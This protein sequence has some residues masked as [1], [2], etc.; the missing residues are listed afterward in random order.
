MK[1]E[2]VENLK[3]KILVCKESLMGSPN[4]SSSGPSSLKNESESITKALSA[5]AIDEDEANLLDALIIL[6]EFCKELAAIAFVK[7]QIASVN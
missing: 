2:K 1:A 3:E 6:E 4:V 5:L 7:Y